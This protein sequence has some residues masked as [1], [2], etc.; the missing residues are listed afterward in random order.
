MGPQG[1]QQTRPDQ[2][3]KF[4][5]LGLGAS[6]QLDQVSDQIKLTRSGL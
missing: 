2:S 6:S 4:L 5:D 1:D 3:P